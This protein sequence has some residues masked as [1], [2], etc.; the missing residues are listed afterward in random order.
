LKLIIL[1]ILLVKKFCSNITFHKLRAF[2]R[3]DKSRTIR[4]NATRKRRSREGGKTLF[5]DNIITR[6]RKRRRKR[7]REREREPI[8]INLALGKLQQQAV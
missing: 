7:E 1:T 8:L 2:V 6:H 4:R 5:V 3:L